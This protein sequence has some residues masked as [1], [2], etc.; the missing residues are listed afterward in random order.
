M[1]SVTED[2]AALSMSDEVVD[3]KVA[4]IKEN[5]QEVIG[6][7]KMREIL[8]KRDLKLYWGTAT[9]GKPHIGYFVPIMK[10]ADFL[11]AGC[12]VTVLFADLHAFLDNMKSTW[13]QLESR[14]QYYEKV[15]K[16][17]LRSRGVNLEKLKFVRGTSFQLSEK[18]T[19]DVYKLSSIVTE[20]QAKKAGAEVVKQS[21]SAPLSGLLYPGLQALD[22][23]YL[24]VDAQ[25]GGLISA[26]FSF[27]QRS[28]YQS[29]VIR[30]GYTL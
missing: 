10:L 18:Y 30:K 13:E 3:K 5:I 2:M 11:E 9:T 22:E 7:E 12:E 20:K 29:L 16:A 19:L 6:E 4:L 23:E 24:E 27:M 25:F 17:M 26:K 1:T 15:I 21:A 28:S 8:K 14:V